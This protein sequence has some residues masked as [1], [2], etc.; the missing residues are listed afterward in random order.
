MILPENP[1]T[2]FDDTPYEAEWSKKGW[3]EGQKATLKAV[4]EWLEYPCQHMPR[5][6]DLNSCERRLCALCWGELKKQV[7]DLK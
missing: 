3:N 1:Y 7:E 2:I 6:S 4:V 5:T